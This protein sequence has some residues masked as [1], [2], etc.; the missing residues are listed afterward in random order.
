MGI[1]LSVMA[2]SIHPEPDAV[3]SN[4]ISSREG[5]IIYKP[6]ESDKLTTSNSFINKAKVMDSSGLLNSQIY[7]QSII[8]E[9]YEN[10]HSSEQSGLSLSRQRAERIKSCNKIFGE[11]NQN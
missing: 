10:I 4:K 6:N 2:S 5:D 11:N 8:S 1:N 3:M 9:F 7:R